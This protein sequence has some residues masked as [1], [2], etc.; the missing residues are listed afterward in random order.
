MILSL[1]LCFRPVML[2]IY[3]GLESSACDVITKNLV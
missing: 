3:L 2:L 1:V